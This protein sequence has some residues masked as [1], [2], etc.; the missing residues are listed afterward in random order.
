MQQRKKKFPGR[1]LSGRWW[2]IGESLAFSSGTEQ[3]NGKSVLDEQQRSQGVGCRGFR[4]I[5][6]S[7]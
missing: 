4:V 7:I 5:L 1:K 2:K 6:D 3:R